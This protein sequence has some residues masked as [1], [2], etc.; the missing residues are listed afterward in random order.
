VN[1]AAD[2]ALV[3]AESKT[4]TSGV[5][6]VE[7]RTACKRR[8]TIFL[9]TLIAA[10]GLVAANAATAASS[11]RD[12]G[13]DHAVFLGV[14]VPDSSP[15]RLL[16]V[17]NQRPPLT[18]EGA[19]LYE[20][21]IDQKSAG[22]TSFDR[23]TWCAGPGMP[24]IMFMPYPLEIQSSGDFIAFVYGWYRWHR[25]V[26]MRDVEPDVPFPTTMGFA[27]GHWE[28]DTLV[29]R[30]IGLSD[31]TV[32]DPSGLPHSDEMALTERLRILNDGR[33]EDRFTIQDRANYV[34]PWDTIMTYH[35]SPGARADDDVCPDRIARGEPAV[36][37][38]R[39]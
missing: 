7:R 27:N 35:R 23:A 30:S 34:R 2:S 33:L 5:S 10:I 11:G 22:D 19:E 21:R 32:L 15:Q 8:P 12:A 20:Q 3:A 17:D 14:W 4:K 28:G 24:R 39:Q 38:G 25:V 29:I 6:E 1:H 9:A 36:A 37:G 18:R 13:Q 16:T 31:V 26:D